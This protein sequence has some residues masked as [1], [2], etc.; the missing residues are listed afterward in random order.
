[1]KNKTLISFNYGP[2]VEIVGDKEQDYFIEFI[3]SRNNKV[4]YSTTIKNNMWTKCS[5]KWHIPW[6]IKVN[7]K[8]AHTFNLKDKD[9]KISLSSKSVGDTLAWAPQ[10]I[11]FAKKYKCKV[12]LS[13]FHN[14]WFKNNPEYK[15]IKFVAPGEEGKY[16]TS[17][18][19]GWFMGDN[20]KWD[21]GS[22]HPI[23]PNTIPLIQSATDILNL[24][25]K[26]INH[27]IN[28]KP[29]KRPKA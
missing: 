23:R 19:I 8:I 9:V 18:T 20:N 10:A 29:G 5:Q 17:F 11:E 28:F 3:D 26:E 2:K 27:G 14:E 15:N 21:V 4:V 12:S 7:N 25:Y 1:M 13:T 6:V 22:Y 24:P 16:Y